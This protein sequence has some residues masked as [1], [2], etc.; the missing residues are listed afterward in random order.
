MANTKNIDSKL[1][2]VK[3]TTSQIV[4]EIN[5]LKAEGKSATEIYA[6]MNA[7]IESALQGIVA[8]GASVKKSYEQLQKQKGAQEQYIKNL[9]TLATQ[10]QKVEAQQTKILAKAERERNKILKRQQ[11]LRNQIAAGN[12]KRTKEVSDFEKRQLDRRAAYYKKKEKE[13]LAAFKKAEKEK[14]AEAKRQQKEREAAEKRRDFRGGFGAQFTPRAIGGA[15]GSLTKYLGIFRLVNAAVQGFTE[16]TV[17]SARE[18]IQFQKALANLGAVAGASATEVEKLGK[19]ALEVAGSTKF[20]AAEIVSLQTE[21]SKLG[22]TAEEVVESTQA[23]AFTAQALGSPLAATAE[24]VGKVINQFDLLVEQSEFVGDV[25]VTTINNSALSFD[26]FGTAIQY[27]GPI[28]KNLGLTFEQ[29]AGAMAVL[30]D[31]GFTASR[32]GTGLRGIFT[33]LGKSSADVEKSLRDLAKEN[34]SLSEAVDLVGKRNAAQ[35]ITL[36]KNIDALDEGSGKYYQQGRAIASA[37][38]QADTFSGQMEILTSNFREFQIEVGNAIAESDLLLGVMDAFF[39]KGAQTARAFK[40]INDIGFESFNNGAEKII[41]GA[42]ATS[43]ALE[44]LNIKAEEYQDTLDNAR[45]ASAWEVLTSLNPFADAK[46]RDDAIATKNSVEGLVDQLN[47][48][49]ESR[50]RDKFISEGQTLANNQYEESVRNLTDAFQEQINVNADVDVLS[51]QIADDIS[52]Y[53]AIVDSSAKSVYNFATGRYDMVELTEE[54]KLKYESLIKT[55]QGY[56][57]QLTNITYSE[58]ELNKK[59]ER[60]QAAALRPILDQI[61]RRTKEEVDAINERARVETKLA[62]TAA[63]RADIEAERTQLVSDAYARQS[64][65]IRALSNEFDTQVDKIEKAALASDDLAK[66]LTSDVIKDVE[67]AVADYT[68]EIGELDEKL[69]SGKITQEEYNAARD[70]QYETLKANIE[71]FKQLGN[72]SPEV[73]ALFDELAKKALEAGYAIGDSAVLPKKN[74]DDF[75]KDFEKNKLEFLE[76]A[77]KRTA[78]VLGEF[79][80]TQLEN[81]KN[82]IASELELIK[83]RYETE[84]YLARQQLENGLINEEQYRRKQQQLRKKQVTE[85]NKLAKELF[86]AERKQERQDAKI[87]AAVATAEIVIDA[88]NDYGFPLGLGVGAALSSVVAAE[89]AGQLSAINQRKFYE[90]KFAK[91]GMVQGPS[92][93]QGG[94]PF[95]VKGQP[96]YEMEGGEFIV[97]KKASSLH[98]ELLE[99]INNSTKFANGGVVNNTVVNSNVGGESVNYLKAIAEATTATAI[100]SSKPVR[101][102]V[103]STD[104]KKDETARRIKENNTTI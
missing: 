3:L 10:F 15:L 9:Q 34:I 45:V 86:E 62:K 17:G 28:A 102:F 80:D 47:K 99:S 85:E 38:K 12:K 73:A 81:T 40:A 36:L 1:Q 53:Q 88:I 89:L 67:N 25:L 91:G 55:L 101:A 8:A 52:E 60:E 48:L 43:T 37:A 79:S 87:N 84:D 19:N 57:D 63:E 24:Q 18:A 76:D 14:T 92:H 104:L 65:S 4:E 56:Q 13:K 20:S 41:D 98:R 93:E 71:A 51:R 100:Q 96:G 44:L 82:R 78:N 5:K 69:R 94:I 6:Q 64:A 22:F 33:E 27:V 103:T 42:D 75:V 58:D 66:I 2:S 72:I 23:I 61:R 21:L 39:P 90:K 30:A 26:S 16:L 54:E 77:I 31:S 68:K 49:A 83:S 29:T 46:M 59:R 32:V 7:K 97:N 95:T 35:L 70:T 74:W 11:N 50:N